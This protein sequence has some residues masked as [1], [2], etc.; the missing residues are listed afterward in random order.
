LSIKHPLLPL[1]YKLILPTLIFMY[2]L[3]YFIEVQG[4]SNPKERMLIHPVFWMMVVLFVIICVLEW[5]TWKAEQTSA[6]SGRNRKRGEA[7]VQ[8]IEQKVAAKKVVS[9]KHEAE[10]NESDTNNRVRNEAAL[11]YAAGDVLEEAAYDET[12]TR[13]TKKTVMY[14]T[15]I[16][17][18]LVLIQPLGFIV[19]TLLY[20]PAV[21]WVLGTRSWKLLTFVPIVVVCVIH[22]LF[23]EWLN[24]PLPS[25]L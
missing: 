20:L 24:I 5:R 13:L 12:K 16:G 25:L 7:E 8:N 14:M 21:M 22:F 3:Y 17:L 10:K 11:D 1:V 19:V 6:E 4:I 2:A 18:Y 23:G 9:R 15:S